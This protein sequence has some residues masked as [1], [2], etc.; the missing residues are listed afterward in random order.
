MFNRQRLLAQ[1]SVPSE[2]LSSLSLSLSLKMLR[3]SPAFLLRFSLGVLRAHQQRDV[4]TLEQDL[5]ESF[6]RLLLERE[7]LSIVEHKV[8]VLVKPLYNAKVWAPSSNRLWLGSR[9]AWFVLGESEDM[10]VGKVCA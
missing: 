4:V 3:A 7:L 6:P 5:S 10:S 8:H 1:R 2:R 9:V